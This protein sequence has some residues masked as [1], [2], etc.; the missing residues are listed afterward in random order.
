MSVLYAVER[1]SLAAILIPSSSSTIVLPALFRIFL[2][3]LL[4]AFRV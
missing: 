4:N 1:G 3:S 2:L